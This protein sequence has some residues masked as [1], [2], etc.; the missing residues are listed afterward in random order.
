MKIISVEAKLSLGVKTLFK[1]DCGGLEA[2]PPRFSTL[3]EVFGGLEP[4]YDRK[5][6][7][8]LKNNF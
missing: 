7:Q 1:G 3:Q 6:F 8:D 4:F 5:R 2:E